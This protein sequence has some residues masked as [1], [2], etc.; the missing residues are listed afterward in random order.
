M[1]VTTCL[2]A[3]HVTTTTTTTTTTMSYPPR[4]VV[5]LR[6]D[7]SAY[8]IGSPCKCRL[9]HAVHVFQ[10]GRGEREGGREG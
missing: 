9:F 4:P 10:E 6:S 3:T 8:R 7:R 2:H 5:H 1:Y